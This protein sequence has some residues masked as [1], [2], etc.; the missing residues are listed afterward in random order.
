MPD[1]ELSEEEE[2]RFFEVYWAE[3]SA[4]EQGYCPVQEKCTY[5]SFVS[6]SAG[7]VKNKKGLL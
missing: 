3:A 6:R 5:I 2:R 4:E 7:R 1:N